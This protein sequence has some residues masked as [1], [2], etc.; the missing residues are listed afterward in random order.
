[1]RPEYRA[2]ICAQQANAAKRNAA[3]RFL[4]ADFP[5]VMGRQSLPGRGFG[6]AMQFIAAGIPLPPALGKHRL[7]FAV[8]VGAIVRTAPPFALADVVPR[9][10]EAWRVPLQKLLDSAQ[11]LGIALHVFGSAAFDALTGHAYLTPQSDIDLLWQPRNAGQ[12]AAGLALFAD[13]E[14][15]TARRLDGEIL[16]G[17]DHA[18]SWRE[19][20]ETDGGGPTQRVLVKTLAGPALWERRALLARLAGIETDAVACR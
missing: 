2:T 18:V 3:A 12:I 5:L 4:A 6:A 1:V 19:W 14:R 16:F 10:Q 9:L 20:M 13:W 11:A 8:P 7:A 15:R 17:A